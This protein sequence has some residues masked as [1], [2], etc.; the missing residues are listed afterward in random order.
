MTCLYTLRVFTYHLAMILLLCIQLQLKEAE[1]IH[2]KDEVWSVKQK[3]KDAESSLEE[4]SLKE[5]AIQEREEILKARHYELTL[6]IS[7]K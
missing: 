1:I 4:A 3:L 5:K 7:S 2:L 6:I